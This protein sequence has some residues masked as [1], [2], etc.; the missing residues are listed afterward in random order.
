MAFLVFTVWDV[1]VPGIGSANEGERMSWKLS[2]GEV[3]ALQA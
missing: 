2:C 3:N 1:S